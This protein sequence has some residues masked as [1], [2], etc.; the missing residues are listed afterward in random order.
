MICQ[1]FHTVSR[2]R[3]NCTYG[4]MRGR[5]Y[6]AGASRSTLHS[7]QETPTGVYLVSGGNVGVPGVENEIVLRSTVTAHGKSYP[8]TYYLRGADAMEQTVDFPRVNDLGK[9][10][11]DGP[12]G[13]RVWNLNESNFGT[14]RFNAAYDSGR[15]S[16]RR[17]RRFT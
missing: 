1:M 7:T 12:A 2:M 10:T 11:V 17:E 9:V 5:T 14:V 16:T 3:E 6:P 4:S 15:T 8:F 13:L